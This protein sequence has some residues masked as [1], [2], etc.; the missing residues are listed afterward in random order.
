MSLVALTA[1]KG[2][3]VSNDGGQVAVAFATKDG[4]ELSVMMPAD[5][6]EALISALN[7]A[8]S[9]AKNKR[10]KASDQVT[11]TLPKTWMVTADLQVRGL[12]LLVFDPKTD[13]QVG[14][15]LDPDSSK[16]LAAGLVKNA[17]AVIAH[18]AKKQN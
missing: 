14:Y 8:K 12:V 11:V 10:D 16:K 9:A 3:A 18:K 5:C 1:V 7:R 17:E 2:H 6:L 4:D 15:G 13:A